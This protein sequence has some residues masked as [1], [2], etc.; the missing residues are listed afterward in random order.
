[1]LSVK[2]LE[3]INL[4]FIYSEELKLSPYAW[5]KRKY[6]LSWSNSKPQLAVY[7]IILF[8]YTADWG[9]GMS[10]VVRVL[11]NLSDEVNL[12]LQLKMLI[13]VLT[14]LFGL[15]LCYLILLMHKSNSVFYNQLFCTHFKFACKSGLCI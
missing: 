1:M 3:S 5:D 13:H 9:Y 10:V 4:L 12:S 6:S 8:L 7:G 14:R 2:S 15:I 11:V